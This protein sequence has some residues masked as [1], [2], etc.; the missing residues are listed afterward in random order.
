MR[1]VLLPGMYGD[2]W[3]N[4]DSLPSHDQRITA[5]F[6]AFRMGPPRVR[7]VRIQPGK[8]RVTQMAIF[9]ITRIKISISSD[10]SLAIPKL[11]T[12]TCSQ[13]DSYQSD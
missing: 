3:Y 5:N 8:T 7:Q 11:R 2:T 4:G 13:N 12:H 9:G 10:R 6:A 1:K